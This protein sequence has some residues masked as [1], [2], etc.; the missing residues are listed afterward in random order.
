MPSLPGLFWETSP[1][2]HCS[3]GA[4]PP[5]GAA[6]D[7]GGGSAGCSIT[8][9]CEGLCWCPWLGAHRP[10]LAGTSC[11]P[12][13]NTNVTSLSGQ[14]NIIPPPPPPPPIFLP[15][16]ESFQHRS[17]NCAVYYSRAGSPAPGSAPVPCLP[18][19]LQARIMDGA[20]FQWLPSISFIFLLF[21]A[22]VLLPVH[23]FATSDT[24]V[25]SNDVFPSQAN[26]SCRGPEQQLRG[27]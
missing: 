21:V 3:P 2:I 16:F 24:L 9:G 17:Y 13:S 27:C 7:W 26:A 12:L 4:L 22:A 20:L 14:I 10:A 6:R 25:G 8:S 1:P 23:N 19:T 5:V 18:I 15:L 11:L